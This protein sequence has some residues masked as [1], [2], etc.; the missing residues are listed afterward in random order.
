MSSSRHHKVNPFELDYDGEDEGDNW[1]DDDEWQEQYATEDRRL[2][3]EYKNDR[4]GGNKNKPLSS[5]ASYYNSDRLSRKRHECNETL[6]GRSFSSYHNHHHVLGTGNDNQLH[7]SQ[8]WKF[9]VL[10]IVVV[11]AAYIWYGE[12]RGEADEYV[13]MID[14]IPNDDY[15]LIILGER[16]SGSEWLRA[17]LQECFPRASVLSNLQRLGFF[18]QEEPTE[19]AQQQHDM[20]VVH[21]TLNIYDW[22]E[23]MRSSPEYAP[24]HVAKHKEGHIVP[25]PWKEFLGKPWT[26]ARPERDIPLQNTTNMTCQQGFQYDQVVSCVVKSPG[27]TDNPVY[28]L[29]QDDGT[30]YESIL[31]LRAA[32]LRNHH[33]VQNWK[34]VK[35]FLT[36]SYEHAGKEFKSRLLNEIHEFTEWAPVCSGD[37]LPPSREHTASMSTEFVEYVNRNADWEAEGLVSY[38]PWTLSDIRQKGIQKAEWSSDFSKVATTPPTEGPTTVKAMDSD[39]DN[40]NKKKEASKASNAGSH[41]HSGDA[42]TE[43]NPDNPNNI[44]AVQEHNDITA[45][46]KIDEEKGLADHHNGKNNVEVEATDESSIETHHKNVDTKVAT[47]VEASPN[48]KSNAT[49]NDRLIM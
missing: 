30:A 15:H 3:E 37:V 8:L 12:E 26:M 44:S 18:F 29:H 17:R 22:L 21:V 25:L 16:H 32:K 45:Q 31:Q 9:G 42:T 35:K 40:E 1:N 49:G 38:K 4:G 5:S 23:Q 41:H 7:T 20:I 11:L 27:G 19:E 33:S 34:Y 28:E 39:S 47:S 6:G 24:N 14:E 48:T 2:M 10:T 36:L 43:R 13:S 46:A